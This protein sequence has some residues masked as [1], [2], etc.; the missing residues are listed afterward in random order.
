MDTITFGRTGLQ[1]T[2]ICF[3]TW[4]LGGDWGSFEDEGVHQA[5]RRARELGVNFFDTAQGYGWG[6]S[7]RLLASALGDELRTTATS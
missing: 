1:V 2:P 3:G 4:Q 5:I 6:A 7:E